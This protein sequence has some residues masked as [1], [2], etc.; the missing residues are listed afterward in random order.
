[1]SERTIRLASAA[2]AA[3][4]VTITGY[5][6]YVRQT[7]GTLACAT[8]GCE[9]VQSSS[10]ADVLGMPVAGLALAGFLGL[11]VLALT[12][13]EWARLGHATLALTAFLFSAYLLYIQVGVIEAIC[14]WCLASD[15]LTTVI[16]ALA[17]LR[18]RIG[19]APAPRPMP[20]APRDPRRRSKGSHRRKPAQR[21]RVR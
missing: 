20:P 17:L 2:L 16:A 10:Y 13:G 7:G 4:G 1:M 11:L 9:T 14:Q 12:R 18:L 8:G 5:L 3:M 6:L 21:T 19:E 15:I